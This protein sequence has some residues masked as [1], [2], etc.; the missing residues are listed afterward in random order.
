MTK[1]NIDSIIVGIDLHKYSHT[2]VALDCF[3][4]ELESLTF[5]NDELDRCVEWLS[6]LGAKK[7]I[8]VGLEDINGHG[9]HTAKRL[10]KEGFFLVYVPPV[11][12]ERARKHTV[13]RDK[14][15]TLDARRVGKVILHRYEETLPATF[16]I[17][18][19]EESLKEIDLL[20]QERRDLIKEQTKLK[21]QLHFLL[22]QLLKDN[23][24]QEF[25]DIFSSKALDFYLTLL[26]KI[27]SFRKKSILRRIER[28]RLIKSQVKEVDL[29]LLKKSKCVPSIEKLEKNLKGC[30]RLTAC[31]V[32]VEIEKISKFSSPHKL[33]KYAA[34]AP[35][36]RASGKSRRLYT[37]PYGNRKLNQAIHTIALSQI[38]KVGLPEAKAYYRKKLSEGK[39]KLWALRCL[40][41]QITNQIFRILTS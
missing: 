32:M 18:E 13:Y 34:T 19:E 38:G 1:L 2:A 31:K 4:R 39:S 41:R 6:G 11:L 14:S 40:K 16:S 8:L 9:F 22:H 5:S 24:R 30:G 26:K 27:P 23:Y 3:G 17:T 35:V 36:E 37:N 25:G 28:L 29:A 20:L 7:R 21:N 10:K 33:A 12:T 15:D